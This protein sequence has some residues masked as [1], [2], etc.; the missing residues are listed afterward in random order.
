[1]NMRTIQIRNNFE[2]RMWC[3]AMMKKLFCEHKY[4]N[5]DTM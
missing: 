2:V 1:M 3:D 4:G 5:K